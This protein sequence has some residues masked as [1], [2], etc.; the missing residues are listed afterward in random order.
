MTSAAV[1]ADDPARLGPDAQVT[2]AFLDALAR[3]CATAGAQIMPHYGDCAVDR[4]ADDSPVT[5]ADQNAETAILEG[6]ARL[7]PDVPVVA[8]E[9]VAGGRC[10]DPC[11]L[12]FLVDPLD[13]TREFIR[14]PA[15]D[16]KGGKGNFT[17]NIGLIHR[18]VPVAGAVYAPATQRVWVGGGDTA[19]TAQLAPQEE[20]TPTDITPIRVSPPD[21]RGPVALCSRSS[22][23]EKTKRYL[24]RYAPAEV[25]ALSSS[26]K[27]CL[28]AAGE[29]HIYARLGR[30]MEWD[31]AAGDAVLR[32]AGGMATTLD[33]AVL[34]Y[35]RPATDDE[36]AYA[37][38][39]FVAV[40]GVEMIPAAPDT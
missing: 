20:A 29:A 4:K 24:E 1:N 17:V 12:F 7:A 39:H 19:W 28:I 38:P 36:Q 40:G 6:L 22:E 31:T 37:N 11:G 30:T 27:L 8:E 21:A 18:G 16:G 5:I 15:S 2:P 13:G 14:G 26:V 9:A 25:R 10:P 3:L 33:G 32:A 34:A 23:P 35:G